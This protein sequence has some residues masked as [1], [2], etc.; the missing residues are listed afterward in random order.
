MTRQNVCAG[1]LALIVCPGQALSQIRSLGST[2]SADAT[3][4]IEV[5]AES[6]QVPVSIAFLPD[7]RAL[8][9]ERQA[10]RLSLVD[11][12]TGRRTTV[13]G[14]PAP[15]TAEDGGLLDVV[16]H[17]SFATNQ[18]V[19]LA[20]SAAVDSGQTTVVDLARLEGDRL[21]ERR[22][23]FTAW[24]AVRSGA[25]FGGRLAL[26]DGFLFITVGDRRLYRELAQDVTTH[27][28]KIIRLH[29]DG[30]V[31]EDNPFTDRAGARP[32]LWSIGHRNPQGLA[33]HP[34]TGQLWASEHGPLGGDEVNLILPGRN[35]GWPVVSFGREYSGAPIGEGLSR[36][37]GI[38][39][40]LHV[41][42]PSI[43]PSGMAFH[44]GDAF[45]AW[46]G[47]L[48]LGAMAQR[49][50]NRL[51]FNAAGRITREERLLQ[52]RRWRVRE[53]RVAPDGALYLGVDDG[54]LVRL[55]PAPSP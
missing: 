9:A 20:Y 44:A 23:I 25:H 1:L 5:V 15:F 17:P 36:R 51:V 54:L 41:Y 14:S 50:L 3:F 43:A 28:G 13:T 55:R 19:Y 10:G 34:I 21:A 47:N 49:H 6:L 52:E 45:P 16:A 32:E 31:P 12:A 46:R 29:D 27:I 26:R 33:F 11:L 48:F 35:Y 39:D 53:V 24:P 37:G 40:P 22:R 18:T 42:A 2:R 30:R 38:E 4:V 7:G 8:L